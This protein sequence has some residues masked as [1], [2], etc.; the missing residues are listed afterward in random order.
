MSCRHLA[1]LAAVER[2]SLHRISRNTIVRTSGVARN[3]KR[4]SGILSALRVTKLLIPVNCA[5]AP[6]LSG[7]ITWADAL[8]GTRSTL[9]TN[10][11]NTNRMIVI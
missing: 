10:I 1:G 7:F 5:F 11:V 4:F 3:E 2:W 8:A 6:A 9:L